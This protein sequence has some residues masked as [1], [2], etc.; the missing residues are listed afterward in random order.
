MDLIKEFERL[1]PEIKKNLEQA[2]SL[3]HIEQIRVAFLG[4]KGQL[5]ALMSKIPSV[6]TS[7]RPV[8]GETANSV[9]NQLTQLIH[10]YKTQLDFLTTT[11]R[12]QNFDAGLPG[13]RPWYGTLHPITIVLEEICSVFT[14]LGYTIATGPEVETEYHNFEAL[15]IPSEHPARDMQDTFYISDSILLRTHTSSIQIRTMLKKQ[16]PIAIIAPGRVYRRDS[17]VTHTPM[18][19]QIEGLVVDKNIS[20]SHLRG[21]LTAFL[22]T[23]FGAEIKIRFR[24]SFF[25]F[26]EPSAEMDISCH[27][28]NNTGYVKN[29]ICRICKGSGWIEILGCGMVHPKVFESVGYDHNIYSGFAFGLG[30]ERIAMLKYHI[31]DLRIF[32]ENDLRFLRQFM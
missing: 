23:I 14:S 26:T 15:G 4:R 5:A 29:E 3:E 10:E 32:F 8:V 6:D 30:V 7:L 9:K 12:I 31:E 24:P 19:H 2:S 25:P 28:C 21:T 20:M 18:F 17:D 22:K 27:P 1:I 16:P 11:N 13:K